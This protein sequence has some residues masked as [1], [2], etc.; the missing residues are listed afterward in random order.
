MH[1]KAFILPADDNAVVAGSSN[2]TYSGLCRNEELGL[3]VFDGAPVGEAAEWFSELW[4]GAVEFD[5]AAIYEARYAEYEPWLIWL[6]ILWERYG[7]E[8]ADEAGAGQIH[9]AKFQVDGVKRA[10]RMLNDNHGIAE[11][12]QVE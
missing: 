6:K 10:M 8:L 2:L 9:L 1:G 4:D 5:L 3:G 12:P 7:V 11:I